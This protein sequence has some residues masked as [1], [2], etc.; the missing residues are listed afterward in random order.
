M[1]TAKRLSFYRSIVRE[2]S[3]S[4]PVPRPNRNPEILKA[5]RNIFETSCKTKDEQSFEY[6]MRNLVLLLRSARTHQALLERYNPLHDLST[7][8]RVKATARRVGLD[9]PV[10]GR[11]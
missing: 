7:Q 8:D 4:S 1:A 3:K 6:S 9:M 11:E 10:E 2:V 5:Y